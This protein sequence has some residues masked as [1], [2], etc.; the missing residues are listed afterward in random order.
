MS[1]NFLCIELQIC[2]YH[3]P[4]RGCRR[5]NLGLGIQRKLCQLALLAECILSDVPETKWPHW[6]RQCGAQDVLIS[7]FVLFVSR[8]NIALA[9]L[10]VWPG[11]DSDSGIGL[12][13]GIKGEHHYRLA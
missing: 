6:V 8:H 13:A 2:V 1:L 10:T 4:D 7:R 11:L 12:S 5:A 9:E 3:A